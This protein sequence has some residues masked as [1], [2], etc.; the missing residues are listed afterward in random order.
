MHNSSIPSTQEIPSTSNLIKSTIVAIIIAGIL[1]VTVVMPAEYGIDPTGIGEATGLKKMGE[2]KVSLAKEAAADRTKD[3]AADTQAEPV[4]PE[5]V[6][7]VPEPM[8][9]TS[10]HEMQVTLAPDEGTEIKVTMT[11]GN[12]V[13]YSWQTDGENASYDEHGDS[14]KLKINYHSYSK[15]SKQKSKGVLEAA[16]DGDHGWFWRNRTSKPMTIILKTNGEYSDIKRF[17]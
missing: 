7:P 14:K 9:S 6:V 8:Q 2:I 10:N 3:M 16:F 13:R 4:K 5:V 12:K 11:K 1:L 17:N 15:G